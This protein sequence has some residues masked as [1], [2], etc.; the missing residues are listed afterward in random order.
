[1]K[2]YFYQ[3]DWN[4]EELIY[5]V[6]NVLKSSKIVY[7]AYNIIGVNVSTFEDCNKL[8]VNF[9]KKHCY[10][11]IPEIWNYY[12]NDNQL[13]YV[14]LFFNFNLRKESSKSV[15]I[16]NYGTWHDKFKCYRFVDRY[17]SDTY[18]YKK[19]AYNSFFTKRYNI[20]FNDIEFTKRFLKKTEITNKAKE[21]PTLEECNKIEDIR[22]KLLQII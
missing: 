4:K 8:A 2:K 14:T 17:H 13:T 15:S 7:H 3:Y 12:V 20:T 1:M 11:L 18:L 6:K 5:F 21:K 16:L 10:S 9:L 22:F 19:Y